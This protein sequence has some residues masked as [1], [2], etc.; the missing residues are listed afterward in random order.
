MILNARRRGWRGG[1]ACRYGCAGLSIQSVSLQ[2]RLGHV[3]HVGHRVTNTVAAIGCGFRIREVAVALLAVDGVAGHRRG[4]LAGRLALDQAGIILL[5]RLGAL[6]D[7]AALFVGDGGDAAAVVVDD[8][9]EA[10]DKDHGHRQDGHHHQGD[11]DYDT[12]RREAQL[13]LFG[14]EDRQEELV[15]NAMYEFSGAGTLAQ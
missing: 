11:A 10:Q 4:R 8:V 14:L 1:V 9:E 13:L 12:P 2:V 5:P 15:R 6:L 7:D 3:R